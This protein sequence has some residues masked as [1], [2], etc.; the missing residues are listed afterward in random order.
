MQNNMAE[1]KSSH[2]AQGSRLFYI[3]CW[4]HLTLFIYRVHT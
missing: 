2:A 1:D 4:R 3:D